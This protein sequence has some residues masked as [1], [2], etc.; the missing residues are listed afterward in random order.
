VIHD[1]VSGEDVYRRTMTAEGAELADA[2]FRE[3]D[4][5]VAVFTTDGLYLDPR[6]PN[7]QLWRP[8]PLASPRDL[9][10]IGR[11]QE[12]KILKVV[13]HAEPKVADRLHPCA[14]EALGE[15]L[16]VTRTAPTLVEALHLGVSK[17]EALQRVAGLLD[18]PRDE[19]I[20]FGD[21]DNDLPMFA[22]AGIRVAMGNAVPEVKAAADLVTLSNEEDGIAAALE[23][24][25]LLEIAVNP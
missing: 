8:P 15:D 18:V 5:P 17:G 14:A 20:A 13:A 21:S 2:F 12:H 19:I 9:R 1:P 10:E 6:I 25:G 16:Y 24:L 22:A 3:R 7:W 23:Q 11:L 4:I